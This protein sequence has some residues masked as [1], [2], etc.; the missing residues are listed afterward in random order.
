M[1]CGGPHITIDGPNFLAENPQFVAGIQGEAEEALPSLINDLQSK[2]VSQSPRILRAGADCAA[3]SSNHLLIADLDSIPDPDY[4]CF[5]SLHGK[6]VD[7]PIITSRGCPYGCIYCCV[8]QVSGNKLRFRSIE[9][10]IMEIE[11]AKK[12]FRIEAFSILDDNF[13]FDMDRAKEICR[14]IINRKIGLP[15]SCPNGIRADRI[16]DELAELMSKSG[17][18]HAS[19]GIESLDPKVFGTINKGET[20][21]DI[22]RAIG[23]LNKHSIKT[24]GFFLI[25]L[26]GDNPVTSM[27]S[28]KNSATMALTTAHWN[29]FVPYPGTKASEWVK[30][31]GIKRGNWENSVHFGPN[32]HPSF[33]TP[34]YSHRQIM[35]M[36]NRANIVSRN[37]S[38]FFDAHRSLPF[39][40]IS[41]VY[42]IARYDSPRLLKHI[43]YAFRNIGSVLRNVY[44]RI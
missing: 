17:C 24:N 8:G 20:I 15:W 37:Y 39:S 26:P 12:D 22:A 16:D 9:R 44:R 40:I 4:A 42:Y 14:A 1:I 28:L 38:A 27:R 29:I 21:E 30:E 19:I 11:K 41:I 25:G 32:A 31:H 2:N 33:E 6:I 35:Q 10:V 18:R 36:Y 3:I 13:S 5:D 43:S 34:E 7:Y 23:H